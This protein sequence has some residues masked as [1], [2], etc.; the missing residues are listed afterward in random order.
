MKKKLAAVAAIMFI[1]LTRPALGTIPNE[2][3][4][5][6]N[7]YE[8]ND[9]S[10][11][12]DE[13]Y[14][15]YCKKTKKTPCNSKVKVCT[16]RVHPRKCVKVVIHERKRRPLKHT[17]CYPKMSKVVVTKEQ[18]QI[19]ESRAVDRVLSEFSSQI[20]TKDNLSATLTERGYLDS[21]QQIPFLKENGY[22][23]I[24]ELLPK[25]D[26]RYVMI[27]NPTSTLTPELQRKGLSL[28][29][30]IVICIAI[31][32]VVASLLLFVILPIFGIKFIRTR[33]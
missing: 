13:A 18:L 28:V 33:V 14:E 11:S 26:Q 30:I 23:S 4:P 24:S 7:C 16:K 9:Y 21:D 29:W 10:C 2:A 19:I 12:Y 20:V 3:R 1:L 6:N 32:L 27:N 5:L 31:V 25:L 15:K 8:Y 22:Y 17:V